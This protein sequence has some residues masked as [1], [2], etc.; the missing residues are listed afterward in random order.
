MPEILSPENLNFLKKKNGAFHV[1]EDQKINTCSWNSSYTI[2][3]VLSWTSQD[4][5]DELK[6]LPVIHMACAESLFFE[7]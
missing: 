6:S 2:L 5:L 1:G 4:L 3:V 7:K